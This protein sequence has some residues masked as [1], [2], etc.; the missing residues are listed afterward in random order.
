MANF[1]KVILAGNLT[2]DPQ[3]SY[4]PS[5]TPVCEF[6][7]AINRKWKGQDGQMRD[8]TC[9]VDCRAYGRQAETFNQYMNKG[10]PVLVEGRLKFDQWE[11]KDGA[12]RSKLYVVVETFQFLGAPGGGGGRPASGPPAQRAAAPAPASAADY[13]PAPSGFQDE[14]PPADEGAAPAGEQIPF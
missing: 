3:L 13:G 8:D 14:M 2:R 11:G 9:F 6:G 12:K 1:N 10:K 4:L 5:N 7:M